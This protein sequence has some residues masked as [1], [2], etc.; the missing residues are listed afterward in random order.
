M[1]AERRSFDTAPASPM[2]AAADLA[3]GNY[4]SS[5]LDALSRA[6][7]RVVLRCG[8][9]ARRAREL[10]DDVLS[11]AGV[12]Q[13]HGV[14]DGTEIVA[15][16]GPNDPAGLVVRYA[17]N[18][19]GASTVYLSS[20]NPVLPADMAAQARRHFAR[21]SDLRWLAVGSDRVAD[22]RALRDE[23][24][25]VITLLGCGTSEPDVLELT[26][27]VG[28]PPE[29]A[30]DPGNMAVVSFTSGITG[31]PRGVARSLRAW[32][33]T[34]R[35]MTQPSHKRSPARGS[36]PPSPG[37]ASGWAPPTLLVTTPLTHTA[38][39]MV[40]AT[41]AT[42]G[43]V[44]LQPAFEAEPVIE[45]A[46]RHEANWAL[47][48][49]THLCQLAE[50]L[51]GPAAE[52]LPAL[53]H[54]VYGG[55]PASPRPLGRALAAF[56]PI[57]R[58][59]YG[60]T[61]TWGISALTP[62]EHLEPALLGTV[63]RPLPGVEVSIRDPSGGAPLPS[64]RAGEVCVRTPL[65]MDGY[66]HDPEATARVLRDGWIHTGDLGHVDTAGYL[67]LVGR[68]DEGM[69]VAGVRVQPAPLERALLAGPDVRAAAVFGAPD[70]SGT[71]RVAVA[72]VL[73][74]GSATSPADIKQTV[75]AAIG[76]FDLEITVTVRGD[77]PL[78]ATGKPDKRRLRAELDKS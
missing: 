17:A 34:V 53:R 21:A 57:L 4:V 51:G 28:H 13:R 7:D 46:R 75:A 49:T 25:T 59:S 15:L 9:D 1:A 50:V 2:G 22:G 35:G 71:E 3:T 24:P 52:Q 74:P 55:S 63:G 36:K 65:A 26:G 32:G 45:A 5:I 37:P 39:P 61:E 18:L 10:S 56:G 68:L 66:W 54:I 29:P 8:E 76:P 14:T 43:S 62:E 48:A 58:Q 38:A 69:K 27:S 40:D 47:F 16:I 64:G 42:G 72:V 19:L 12:M 23:S 78:T 20:V 73:R 44:L 41:L 30:G 67:T 33:A 70:E 60:T 31:L 6:D 11:A 77:L